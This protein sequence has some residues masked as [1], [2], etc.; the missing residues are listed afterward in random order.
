MWH[1]A[2]CATCGMTFAMTEEFYRARND[3]GEAF[4]CPAGHEL[5]YRP[6]KAELERR[7]ADLERREGQW[8]EAWDELRA[9][10]EIRGQALA[11]ERRR[12]AAY[13]QHFKRVK[14]EKVAGGADWRRYFSV[15]G[16]ETVDRAISVALNMAPTTR[17]EKDLHD[18]ALMVEQ[19][20]RL[21]R[22]AEDRGVRWPVPGSGDNG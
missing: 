11:T 2:K 20:H 13:K 17:Q 7:V 10:Y 16:L 19:M 12:A 22:D 8:E 21:L 6:S 3:D 4:Y 18:F 9:D 15:F 14:A 1:T 5:V